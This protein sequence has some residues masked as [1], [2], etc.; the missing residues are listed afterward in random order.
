MKTNSTINR[1][2]RALRS[3]ID[4]PDADPL[5]SRIAW[6]VEQA[7]RWARQDVKSW[8]RPLD[9]ASSCASLLRQEIGAGQIRL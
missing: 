9:S 3:Y 6:E 5:T 4:S 1:E 2:L 7:I 8:P